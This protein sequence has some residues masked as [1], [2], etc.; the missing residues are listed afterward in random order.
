MAFA[1]A[2]Q[3]APLGPNG[4]FRVGQIGSFPG[5]TST[6]DGTLCVGSFNLGGVTK[7]SPSGKANAFISPGYVGS[8]SVLGVLDEEKSGTLCVCSNDLTG[9]GISSPGDGKGAWLKTLDLRTGV[10]KGSF[11]LKDEKSLCNDIAV[12]SDRTAYATDSFA[13]YVYSSGPVPLRSISG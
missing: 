7:I 10:A 4:H 9:L 13:P 3:I 11:A 12:G 6:S 5:V 1:T 2:N 8:R